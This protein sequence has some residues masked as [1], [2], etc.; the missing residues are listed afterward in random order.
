MAE[1]ALN[2]SWAG[3]PKGSMWVPPDEDIAF[4]TK[5]GGMIA[6]VDHGD[7]AIATP[8]VM[9]RWEFEAAV[10]DYMKDKSEEEIKAFN[11][12]TLLEIARASL[13]DAVSTTNTEEQQWDDATDVEVQRVLDQSSGFAEILQ[14]GKES[15]LIGE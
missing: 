9:S 14:N 8:V 4:P 6:V 2:L 1:R 15:E 3:L 5:S 7:K 10:I 12:E 11:H 13:K